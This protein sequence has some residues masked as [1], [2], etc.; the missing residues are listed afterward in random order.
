MPLSSVLNGL[1]NGMQSGVGLYDALSQG[2]ARKQLLQAQAQKATAEADPNSPMNQMDRAKAANYT[3][4]ANLPMVDMGEFVPALRGKGVRVAA[5]Q[6][7]PYLLM[8]AAK[9]GGIGSMNPNAS[10]APGG[11]IPLDA[12]GEK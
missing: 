8:N 6:A 11:G 1:S 3:R 9:S 2:P 12:A 10:G 5:N 4:E 7:M